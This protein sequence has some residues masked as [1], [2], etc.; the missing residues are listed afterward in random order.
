M[1]FHLHLSYFFIFIFI[2]PNMHFHLHLSPNN[3]SPQQPPL[4]GWDS[5]LGPY[6]PVIREKDGEPWLYGRGGADDG[7][8]IF[9]ACTAVSAIKKQQVLH[10]RIFIVIE[11]SEESGSPDLPFYIE[12]LNQRLGKVDFVVCL[13]SGA[14]TYNELWVSCSQNFFYSLLF[15]VIIIVYQLVLFTMFTILILSINL[16]HLLCSPTCITCSVHHT[17]P[18]HQL[19]LLYSVAHKFSPW[20]D[21]STTD[22]EFTQGGGA[23]WQEWCSTR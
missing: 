19:V 4:D 15:V 10:P 6:K 22:S 16:Q 18:V 14:G 12:Q 21:H 20:V 1:H 11:G 7:Y 23:L 8:A 2:S 17:Y 5:E 13:D 3:A 9:A